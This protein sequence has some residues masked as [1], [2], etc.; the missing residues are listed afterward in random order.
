MLERLRTY[1]RDLHGIPELGFD[2]PKT[3]QYVQGV[4]RSLD[5]EI[6]YP[7][8]SAICAFF[9]GGK[10]D[11]LAFRA[12]LDALPVQEATGAP[13]VSRH[14]GR[15]HA[16]GHDGH[17][18]LL[19]AFAGLVQERI[20]SLAHNV[21]L[22]FQPA[23]ETTGGARLICESNILERYNT[24]GIFALHLW[25]ELPKGELWTRPGPVMAKTGIVQVEIEGKSAHVA[26]AAEGADALRAGVD[27]LSRAYNMAETLLPISEER[28][29]KFGLMQSGATE[30]AL[31]EHTYIRGTMRAFSSDMHASMHVGLLE[32]AASIESESGCRV[33]ISLSEGYP[34]VINDA[35][36]YTRVMAHL[37]AKGPKLLSAPFLTGEDFSFYQ[38]RVPGLF[39]FL[40]TGGSEPLHASTFDFDEGGLLNGLSLYER[41]L[42]L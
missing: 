40:G 13:Y 36:L 17:T 16:C 9:D 12:D 28:L 6:S 22:I 20:C 27:F 32:I 18:A 31:S 8:Q 5:C 38:Q 25:P 21:L 3:I 39:F 30:N 23:E 26:R 7:A 29:L 37:G 1:R 34:P 2:L 15:M 41:L 33:R 11:T 35:E 4:L 14:L 24:S 10:A 19:L 42:T